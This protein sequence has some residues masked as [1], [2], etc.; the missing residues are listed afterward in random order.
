MAPITD[1]PFTAVHLAI[2]LIWGLY[3]TYYLSVYLRGAL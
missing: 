3:V 1:H 2:V